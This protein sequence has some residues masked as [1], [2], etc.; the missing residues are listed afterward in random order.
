VFIVSPVGII[1]R[2]PLEV[3]YVIRKAG[4][5]QILLQSIPLLALSMFGEMLA[6]LTLSVIINEI[7]LIP[8]LIILVPAI[9]DLRG[10]V[11]TSL[12]SRLS[13]C[14]HE[15]R[16]ERLKILLWNNV[17]SAFI[18][19]ILLSSLIGFLAHTANIL[20]GLPSTG[21][22]ELVMI[23]LV[24]ALIAVIFLSSFTVIVTFLSFR[25]GMDPDNVV[26]PGLATISDVVTV[27]SIL[28]AARF[29]TA[30]FSLCFILIEATVIILF[31]LFCFLEFVTRKKSKSGFIRPSEKPSKIILES[32]PTLILSAAIGIASGSILHMKI[33]SLTLMPVLVALIPLVIADAGIIGSVLGARLSS[34]LHLGEIEAYKWS[35]LLLKNTIAIFILGNASSA[36]IGLLVYATFTVLKI[37]VLNLSTML[38]FSFQICFII[39]VVMIIITTLLAFESFKRELDPSNIVIPIMTSLG[40]VIGVL[41]L[42]AIASIQGFI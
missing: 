21:F 34:A 4:V 32:T 2:K 5:F 25:H 37:P 8:G 35:R 1:K 36:L 31:I 40:D 19:S 11:G 39:T 14:L 17:G 15:G 13:V 7:L 41:S 18:L 27:M 28:L 42:V 23:S 9:S 20:L 10:D 29:V 33:E 30:F 6:G 24:S 3:E 22:V 16:L 26:A 12:G 38:V